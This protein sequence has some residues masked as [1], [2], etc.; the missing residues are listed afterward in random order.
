MFVDVTSGLGLTGTAYKTNTDSTTG[1]D[2]LGKDTFLTLLVTQLGNQDPLN[3]MADTEF[4]SQLAQFSSLEQ[5]TKIA[6][7]VDSLNEGTERQDMLTAV[8]FIGKEV[9]A[10]GNT[11][12]KT[13]EGITSLWYEIEEPMKSGFVNIYDQAGGLVQSIALGP[14]QAGRY[15][16]TWDGTDYDGKKVANGIY[17]VG[18]SC[19]GANGEL[20]LVNMD[21]TG[22][23]SGVK[24]QSGT[25]YLQLKDGRTV[26]FASIKEV[27][28]AAESGTDTSSSSKKDD[29]T[30]D[31]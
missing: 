23:V 30:A 7:G 22:E 6:D 10:T 29:S 2:E 4:T 3:P 27:V 8:S 20:V 14:H 5:L 13:D 9:V 24:T 26:D 1:S 19:E 18:M 31:S 11:F 16:V 21:V 28:G 12:S 25:F 15:E 17:G